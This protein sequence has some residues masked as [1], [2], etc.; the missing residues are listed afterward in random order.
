MAVKTETAWK[1][2]ILIVEDNELNM[3]LVTAL[4]EAAGC[5]VLQADSGEAAVR[6]AIRGQPDLILMD[7]ALPGMDGLQA[8]ETLRGDRRARRIPIIALTAHAMRGD[9]ERAR[10]AGCVGYITKPIDT[11]HFAEQIALFLPARARRKAAA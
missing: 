10:A 4:L 1:P 3:E 8:A 11:R 7:I 2:L 6:Q 9:E 5:A